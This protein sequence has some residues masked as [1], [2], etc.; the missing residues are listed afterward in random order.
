[1]P[2][3]VLDFRDDALDALL[4]SRAKDCEA[5]ARVTSV[6]SFGVV[7][8]AI[9]LPFLAPR[10]LRLLVEVDRDVMPGTSESWYSRS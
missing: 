3:D 8:E 10:F 6:S 4:I 2:R 9:P 1:L 5:M 7:G